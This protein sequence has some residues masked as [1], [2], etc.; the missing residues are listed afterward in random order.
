VL[1]RGR[2]VAALTSIFIAALLLYV[3]LVGAL[4]VAQ[5]SLMY[6]PTTR[7]TA[8]ADA[9]FPQAEEVVLDTSDGEKVIAWHVAPKP[10]QPIVLFFHGNGD[11][12]AGLI[13]RFHQIVAPGVGLL[14]LSYR[15]YAGSTGYPTED[16]LHRDALAAYEFAAGRYAP[17]RIVLWGFSLGTGVAVALAA[18]RPI[19]K[20]VLEAPFTSA[21][22][23][24]SSFYPFVPVRILMK[25]QFHSD[26]HI[27]AVRAPILILHGERD[28]AVPISLGERLFA[29][30]PEPKRFVRFPQGR[31]EDLGN[32]GVVAE[33]LKFPAEPHRGER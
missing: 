13:G 6:F 28:Q 31:H 4:Y 18:K 23:V 2:A 12:L 30:A 29:M 10:T 19:A 20:L 15:G 9:G 25:D 21:A 16:G 14:A 3:G 26:R 1:R 22:D 33:V 24:A 32:Y 8:P 17:D 27:Q 7:R 11:F 5:R